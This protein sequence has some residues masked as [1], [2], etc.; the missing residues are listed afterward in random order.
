MMMG[1]DDHPDLTRYRGIFD[2]TAEIGPYDGVK[3]STPTHIGTQLDRASF[4]M[5]LTYPLLDL[6]RGWINCYAHLQWFSGYAESLRAYDQRSD[7]IL[8]GLSFVR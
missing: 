6:T 4:Q 1:L 2:L 8:I 3:V 7:R 5:D